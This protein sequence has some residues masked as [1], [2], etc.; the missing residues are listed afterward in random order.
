M[1]AGMYKWT[2]DYYTIGNA[3]E[4]PLPR[5]G[6]CSDRVKPIRTPPTVLMKSELLEP[7]EDKHECTCCQMKSPEYYSVAPA[8]SPSPSS[9]PSPP[10]PVPV[11]QMS[12]MNEML[13]RGLTRSS[14]PSEGSQQSQRSHTIEDYDT[15]KSCRDIPSSKDVSDTDKKYYCTKPYYVCGITNPMFE[16]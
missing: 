15:C 1:Y 14:K 12:E 7:F 13:P 3:Y 8:G 16:N 10:A 2:N 5:G 4:L 6:T 9:P 11:S